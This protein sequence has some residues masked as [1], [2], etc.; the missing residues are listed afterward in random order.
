[1]LRM[2]AFS[3]RRWISKDERDGAVA[4]HALFGLASSRVRSS[5]G[6]GGV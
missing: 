1:M 2:N 4:P 3:P 6:G 5:V